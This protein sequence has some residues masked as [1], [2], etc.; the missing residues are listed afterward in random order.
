[1][2]TT[3]PASP[4]ATLANATSPKL[5]PVAP[6]VATEPQDPSWW[7]LGS[8]PF[9]VLILAAAGLDLAWPEEFFGGIGT[10]IGC[11][12][13]CAAILLLRRDLSKGEMCFLAALGVISLLALGVS[14]NR[15][16]WALAFAIPVALVLSPVQKAQPQGS[17]RTWWGY[18][19][20]RRKM[21]A[22]GRWAWLRQVLPTLITVFVGV[23][24]FLVFLIIF[25][26]GNPVVLLVWNTIKDWWN[27]LVE[28]LELD[29]DFARHVFAWV[30]AF[31]F[32]GIYTFARPTEPQALPAVPAVVKSGRSLLPHLPLASLIGI[33]LAFI[34]AT[35]TDMGY[36]WFG[37]VPAGGSQT[38][39]LHDGAASITWAAA[40]ASTILIVLFRPNALARQERATRVAGYV[41]VFQTFLLAVSVY[42]RLYHQIDDYGFT[43][44][45]IQAAEALLLGLDGLV[46]LVC[47]MACSGAFWKY[48]RI[49]LG[50]MLLIFIAY[51][52]C[53]PAELAGNLNLRYVS[54]HEKW[55]FTPQDFYENCFRVEENLAFALYVHERFPDNEFFAGRV[56][57]AAKKVEQRAAH[58][59]WCH[60]NLSLRR[61]LPAAEKILGHPILPQEVET[62]QAH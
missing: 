52:I 17:F 44:R 4:P 43:T 62:Q 49:C 2:D 36:L 45:R 13:W 33:N 5:V 32:F 10:G 61:D 39:Y 50:S 31:F 25:A 6:A 60:W 28:W 53:P 16:N 9:I 14:G 56:E 15:L 58:E 51:G 34:I 23:S 38:A 12:L 8:I 21:G 46:I 47:Y 41:L 19:F 30:V 22:Q 3:P 57:S 54:T 20:A 35:G 18:W 26:S 27:A 29:W 48:A 24:L 7:R 37:G 55:S 59:G 42:V 11:A 40:L 1:M